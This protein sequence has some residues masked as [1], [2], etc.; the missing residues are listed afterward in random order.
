MH[1]DEIA[2]TSS[3]EILSY[4]EQASGFKME[5]IMDVSVEIKKTI[6]NKCNRCWK[7]FK[8][9]KVDDICQRCTDSINNKP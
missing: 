6:G 7:Y 5:D 3:Y 2:I 9:V 8:Q 1:L 4:N